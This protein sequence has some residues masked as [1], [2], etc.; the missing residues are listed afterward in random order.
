MSRT[1]NHYETLDVSPNASQAEIKQAYRALVKRFHPDRNP[2]SRSH[3]RI[4]SIN[5][6]YEVLSDPFQ[7]RTYDRQIKGAV[8][9][10]YAARQER[11]T[12]AQNSY[13][14]KRQSGRTED[15]QLKRWVRQTYQP[16]S[17][18][19]AQILNPLQRQI[20][21]LAADPFDD[22]LMEDF[23][24]YL[25]D[26]R[27]LLDRAHQLFQAMPNP[28]AVAGVAA[29]LYYC[30]NQ[31]GDGLD[32][33]ERFTVSYSEHYLHTGQELFRIAWGLRREA[34]AAMQQCQVG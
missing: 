30:L 13:R 33:L 23:Q 10:G 2:G 15:E 3:D 26:C 6:A 8:A 1:P 22:E 12:Q 34:Q 28:P 9:S 4:A 21:D 19:I 20:D 17:R 7:R 27:L 5:V 16:V 11:A 18:L 29:H 31:I 14:Q 25:E 32:E 24:A